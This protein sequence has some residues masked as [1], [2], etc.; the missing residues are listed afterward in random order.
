[1][2]AD[3]TRSVAIAAWHLIL[4]NAATVNDGGRID[5][6]TRRIAAAICEPLASIEM[7]YSSFEAIGLIAG[8]HVAAWKRRQYE[9]DNSTA[10]VK[11]HRSKTAETLPPADNETLHGRCETPPK[12][13]T[14]D[15][16]ANALGER[17]GLSASEMTKA[18]FDS[19]VVL[20]CRNGRPERESRSVIGRWRKTYND[21]Q[22]L[23][24]LARCPD[25]VSEPLEW[26]TA[27][28]QQESGNGR[29]QRNGFSGQGSTRDLGMEIAAELT[30]TA[31][32]S[33]SAVDELPRIGPPG[34]AIG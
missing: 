17:R 2:V 26:V 14:E 4:E 29:Q 32:G 6:P 23:T 33:R 16:K 11:K 10:R 31:G 1:M 25:N 20:L 30:R 9:S 27:A 28:L 24:V 22:V 21:S 19:G 18:I 15:S 8:S 7:L 3:C 13:E 5:I 12:T 34:R